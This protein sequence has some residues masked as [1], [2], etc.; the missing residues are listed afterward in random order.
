[1]GGVAL[2]H[3][4]VAAICPAACRFA[5]LRSPSTTLPVLSNYAE[6]PVAG[7]RDVLDAFRIYGEGV[8]IA[9][10]K[11]LGLAVAA[12]LKGEAFVITQSGWRISPS[13]LSTA[14]GFE[15][16]VPVNDAAA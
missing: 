16:I 2:V 1:M 14:F 9:L 10:P 8:G 6:Y 5:L 15:Q 3:A 11:R 7:L 12:P 4:V 13:E